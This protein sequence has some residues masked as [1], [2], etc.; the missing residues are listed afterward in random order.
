VHN[1]QDKSARAD[2][3]WIAEFCLISGGCGSLGTRVIDCPEGKHRPDDRRQGDS[4]KIVD[5]YR[6]RADADGNFPQV[7]TACA[8]SHNVA[9]AHSPMR[10]SGRIILDLDVD[11][12]WL[13][14][15]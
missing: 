2:V 4:S 15:L 7:K 10:R 6:W 13:T 8:M 3:I 14:Y 11:P 5:N 9:A 1:A 12:A